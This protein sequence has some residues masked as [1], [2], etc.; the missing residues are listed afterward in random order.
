M[1]NQQSPGDIKVL[2]SAASKHGATAEIADHIGK[3]LEAQGLDLT[4][5]E[6]SEVTD[7]EGY[8]A[9]ILGSAIYAGH[10]LQDAKELAARVAALDPAPM[11][12]MFSSG[13]IGD[14]P[15]PEQDPVDVADILQATAARQHQVFAGKIDTSKLSFGEKAI[16]IAV[17][18]TEG[19]FRDWDEIACWADQIGQAVKAELGVSA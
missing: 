10:W 8:R 2:V 4:R 6:P 3:T 5:T 18:A 14:P 9:V 19:D 7:L 16:M 17:R 1:T 11:V 13:P 12:W 15:K